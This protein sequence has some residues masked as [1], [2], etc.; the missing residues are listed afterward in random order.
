MCQAL[1]E[2]DQGNYS[3]AVELLHPVRYRVTEIGGSDA[4]VRAIADG[5]AA[6]LS[7]TTAKANAVLLAADEMHLRLFLLV[8][9]MIILKEFSGGRY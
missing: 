2:Y 4:Q 3:R 8:I 5:N 6:K 9:L 7:A 1:V